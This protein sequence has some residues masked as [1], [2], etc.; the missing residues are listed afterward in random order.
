[1]ALGTSAG[2]GIGICTSTVT[3]VALHH[4]SDP[5]LLLDTLAG[6]HEVDRHVAVYIA[7]TPRC[8]GTGRSASGTAA[9]A[10]EEAAEDVAQIAEVEAA[11]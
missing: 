4:V 11:K 2:C 8:I 10:A 3:L 7:A 5:H 1:M 6:F 9:E